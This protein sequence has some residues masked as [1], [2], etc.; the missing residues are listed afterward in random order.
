M[1]AELAFGLVASI[2]A[3]ITRL[4][5]NSRYVSYRLHTERRG[6]PCAD[7]DQVSTLS[8]LGWACT[9]KSRPMSALPP[10]A[11]IGKRGQDVRLVPIADLAQK[12]RLFRRR[13]IVETV[14][15]ENRLDGAI[16][17]EFGQGV[18]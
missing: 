4:L 9:H 16:L 2:G 15:A 3:T 10:K 12:R 14:L 7:S 6:R 1:D 13:P 11:D 17:L 18:V 8:S 5:G